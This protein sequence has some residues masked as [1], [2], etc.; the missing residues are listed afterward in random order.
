MVDVEDTK[1]DTSYTINIGI[2]LEPMAAVEEAMAQQKQASIAA[3]GNRIAANGAAGT[4]PLDTKAIAG[5][6]TKI[7]QHAYNF[8]SGF[9]DDK[10][11]VPLKVFDDWWN[12]FKS[13]LQ[14]NPKFLTDL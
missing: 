13:R 3:N 4:Q 14:N 8:M 10:G 9:T 5:I 7:Y 12:K 6:S 11:M 2:S 1:V